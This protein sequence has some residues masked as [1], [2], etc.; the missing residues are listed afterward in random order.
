MKNMIKK[1]LEYLV[2]LGAANVTDVTL[3]DGTVQTY[4]DKPLSRIEK[5]IPR[6]DEVMK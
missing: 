1:A 5:H 3:P 2:E 6:A 4:S